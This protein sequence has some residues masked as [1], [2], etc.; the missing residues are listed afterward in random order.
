M[1]LWSKGLGKLVLRMSLAERS[2]ASHQD[3]KLVIDGT[4]GAPTHW[5]YA[6]KMNEDD[7]LD[8]VELLKQPA[9]VRFAIEGGSA[10][11]LVSTALKS[12]V[13]FAWNTIRCFL[14]MAPPVAEPTVVIPP[15]KAPAKK[16]KASANGGDT[17]TD[18]DDIKNTDRSE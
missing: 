10:G 4:M 6:V 15:P 11:R 12:G 5:D 17:D 13:F 14:G 3:G 16:K 7:V 2:S 8:F 9:P 1:I 18:T